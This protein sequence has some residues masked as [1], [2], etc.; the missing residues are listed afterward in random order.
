MVTL[1]S[2][3]YN[4]QYLGEGMH[5]AWQQLPNKATGM[6]SLGPP[7]LVR[8]FFLDGRELAS[9]ISWVFGELLYLALA[10]MTFLHR[11]R[12]LASSNEWAAR[13]PS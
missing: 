7:L 12:T 3:A 8:W 5:V 11:W 4:L 6:D 1:G 13:T 10:Y 2:L 9:L